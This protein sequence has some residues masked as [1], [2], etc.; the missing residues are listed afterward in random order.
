MADNFPVGATPILTKKNKDLLI[1][2]LGGLDWML[3]WNINEAGRT[4]ACCHSAKCVDMRARSR[5]GA[6]SSAG[7]H[8][9]VQPRVPQV[10]HR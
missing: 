2:D 4:N 8:S 10:E 1:I 5:Q 3:F 6:R 9:T 7:V